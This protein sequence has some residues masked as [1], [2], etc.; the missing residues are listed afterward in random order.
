MLSFTRK[1]D[2][3]LISLAHCARELVVHKGNVWC[4]AREIATHYGMPM[5]L[6]MN[7]L[8]ALTQAG[9]ARSERGPRGGYQL[10]KP[11][12]EITLCEIIEAVNGPFILVKCLE[13]PDP[14]LAK[15]AKFGNCELSA[16]CPVRPQVCRVHHRLLG[17]L[18]EVTLAEIT[19]HS[20]C[21]AMVNTTS[22]SG[23][24]EHE[25]SHL[26]R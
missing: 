5:P 15:K 9:L 11:P 17:F 10:A 4:S 20:T 7:V 22:K 12:E 8:K 13:K 21:H 1:T 14:A 18:K 2:Y 24:Q 25:I 6:L 26:P 3:A 16:R 23:A 19:N